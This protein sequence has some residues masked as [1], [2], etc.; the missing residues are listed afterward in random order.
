MAPL[1]CLVVL[2]GSGTRTADS[3][4]KIIERELNAL[5]SGDPYDPLKLP[6]WNAA[7]VPAK[8][9]PLGKAEL[10]PERNWPAKLTDNRL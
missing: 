8:D 5:V 6:G 1:A 3:S 4:K 7:A 10:A 2:R 9:R